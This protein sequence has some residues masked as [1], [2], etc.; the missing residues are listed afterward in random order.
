VADMQ[1]VEHACRKDDNRA[2]ITPSFSFLLEVCD[3]AFLR[4]HGMNPASGGAFKDRLYGLAV[5]DIELSKGIFHVILP[6]LKLILLGYST[7][8]CFE[9]VRQLVE[10]CLTSIGSTDAGVRAAD[11]QF[12]KP[13]L[14]R[15]KP[16]P[17]IVR[18]R[19]A[20]SP[21]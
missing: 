6:S 21:L 2:I 17:K 20:G 12:F 19:P 10:F 4:V 18:G 5:N 8:F 16:I 3:G 11:V 13:P 7:I 15:P 9:I 14:S 1:N